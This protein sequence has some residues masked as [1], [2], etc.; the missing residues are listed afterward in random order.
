MLF[1]ANQDNTARYLIGEPGKNN[2][3]CIGINPAYE[4]IDKLGPTLTKMKKMALSHKYDGWIAINLYPIRSSHIQDISFSNTILEENLEWI[5]NI[6]YYNG[7]IWACWGSGIYINS[8]LG[9][10]LTKVYFTLKDRD[11]YRAGP[12][13]KDGHPHHPVRLSNEYTLMPFDIVNYISQFF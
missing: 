1:Q 6:L 13:S 10:S 2:L 11:W 4:T 5:R 12:L 9:R 8:I 7:D 3:I